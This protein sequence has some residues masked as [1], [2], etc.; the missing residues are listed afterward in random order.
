MT[1]VYKGTSRQNDQL[2]SSILLRSY[3]SR[4]ETAIEPNC[5]VWQAGRATAA[6]ALAFKPIQVG[7]STFLDEG[8]GKYNPAPQA[9][10]EAVLSEWPGRE[11]G[12][13]VSI[14]TGKRPAGT[15]EQQHLWW[16]GF[17]GGGMGDFAEAR[18]RLISKIEGCEDTH[19][20]MLNKHLMD[21]GV[22]LDNYYRL[23]VD[24]GVGEFGM[25]EWN[26]LADIST[27]TRRYLA[28]SEVKSMN[29]EA[30]AKLARIY[31]ASQRWFKASENPN[32]RFSWQVES[33]T[34][35][36]PAVAGA[37][38]LPAEDVPPNPHITVS[39]SAVSTTSQSTLSAPQNYRPPSDEDKF[40]VQAPEPQ[41]WEEQ[42]QQQQ[43]L[44][45]RRSNEQYSQ[46]HSGSASF[47]H[48]PR[49]SN[50]SGRPP[51][52]NTSS[53]NLAT[54][55]ARH[56][57]DQ[58]RPPNP[59]EPP[60]RP[61]KTPINGPPPLGAPPPVPVTAPQSATLT[62]PPG[63][64]SVLPYPDSDGP[65]GAPPVNWRRKPEIGGSGGL[66]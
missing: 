6:T 58:P 1:A 26:R 61:P 43:Q 39:Q 62:R 59:N 36:P 29:V 66:R 5:T 31:K 51:A 10:D 50:E 27:N 28:T 56:S 33:P 2:Y 17:V 42:Q 32:L 60:P 30:A 41:Q 52:P 44:S 46:N 45:Q 14:G 11:V 53:P 13:L 57:S 55:Q 34:P 38:E 16:E 3:D 37:I 12:I 63:G 20:Y 8:A 21:R 23:N 22:D 64:I 7:Q 24:V 9:L 49:R 47:P 15:N 54:A 4:S 19:M 18:R 40:I 35:P 25:N 48:L 65:P